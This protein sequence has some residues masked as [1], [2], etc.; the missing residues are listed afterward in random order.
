VA[1]TI[2]EIYP[3]LTL[4]N[5]AN[6]LMR[7]MQAYFKEREFFCDRENNGATTIFIT[8][9]REISERI[10]DQL[11]LNCDNLIETELSVFE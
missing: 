1:G 11:D 4:I 3:D 7:Q 9:G 8:A 6:G 2:R 5:P 10:I